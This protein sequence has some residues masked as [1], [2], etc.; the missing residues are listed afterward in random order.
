MN[1]FSV[2]VDEEFFFYCRDLLSIECTVNHLIFSLRNVLTT[3]TVCAFTAQSLVL[4]DVCD[5]SKTEL[6][7]SF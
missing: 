1:A 4:I 5:R 7:V 3:V 2:T 6:R